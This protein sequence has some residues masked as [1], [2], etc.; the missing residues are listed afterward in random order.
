MVEEHGGED[1]LMAAVVNEKGKAPKADAEARL[2]EIQQDPD[3]ED[4]FNLLQDYLTLLE[5]EAAAWKKVS[6]AQKTLEEATFAQ[7]RLLMEA[8]IKQL[9]VEDKWLATLAADVQT[10]LN[11]VSQA[12]TGRL[13][14]L[15]ER[16]A[17]PM[18]KLL[19]E[20]DALSARVNHHLSKMGFHA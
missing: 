20:V 3:S 5:K 17:I 2:R 1:G 10:E 9:V 19:E 15:A 7:F 12:L 11:R 8:D 13:K 14:Q 6:A 16:Y 18:P 4:E